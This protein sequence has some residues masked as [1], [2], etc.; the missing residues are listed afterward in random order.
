VSCGDEELLAKEG[1]LREELHLGTR[2]IREEATTRAAG[3]AQRG[4]ES[5]L[6]KPASRTANAT[7][8]FTPVPQEHQ[9][10]GPS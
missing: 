5:R 7:E 4:C 8:D 1:V 3:L 10:H 6:D 2:E 9:E